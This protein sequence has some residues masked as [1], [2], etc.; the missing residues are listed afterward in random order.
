MFIDIVLILEP[1]RE[2]IEIIVIWN[3]LH[4]VS[5]I[6]PRICRIFRGKAVAG[7]VQKNKDPKISI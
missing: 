2:H 6:R 1:D 5:N 4:T 3:N 7:N